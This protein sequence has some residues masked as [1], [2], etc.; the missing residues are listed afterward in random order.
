[1]LTRQS[2]VEYHKRKY[3]PQTVRL[4][5]HCGGRCVDLPRIGVA[6][7]DCHECVFFIQVP[8]ASMLH[9]QEVIRGVQEMM[10]II[11]KKVEEEK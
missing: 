1:M 6:C 8:E 4:C 5:L 7:L 9:W 3:V 2:P 11:A 10:A